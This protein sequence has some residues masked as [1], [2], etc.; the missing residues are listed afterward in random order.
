MI[1]KISKSKFISMKIP[2]KKSD[3]SEVSA[4]FITASAEIFHE[5]MNVHQNSAELSLSGISNAM[6]TFTETRRSEIPRKSFNRDNF[7]LPTTSTGKQS[8]QSE[9]LDKKTQFED[10]SSKLLKRLVYVL[11]G[12]TL[13]SDLTWAFSENYKNKTSHLKPR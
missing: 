11:A 8:R 7:Q 13:S 1:S 5:R 2:R 12:F 4:V 10:Q 3:P 9:K 6:T